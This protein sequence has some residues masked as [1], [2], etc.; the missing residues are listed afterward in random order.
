[1][2]LLR[3]VQR[4][5]NST[6]QCLFLMD[7]TTTWLV[8]G[9]A[10][11]V[12]GFGAASLFSQSPEQKEEFQTDRMFEKSYARAEKELK[13]YCAPLFRKCLTYKYS[14][15]KQAVKKGN[16]EKIVIFIDAGAA[17]VELK[18]GKKGKVNLAPD[19]D[20]LG[21]LNKHNVEIKVGN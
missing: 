21:L 14:E 20:L 10:V 12:I 15:F 5:C 8:R 9:A 13:K 6:T 3:R 11:V 18:D 7:K 2:Y 17:V 16:V 4:E 19:Q 1:M